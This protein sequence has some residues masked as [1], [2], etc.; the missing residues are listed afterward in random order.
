[1]WTRI[2]EQ[3][4]AN[5]WPRGR[6]EQHDSKSTRGHETVQCSLHDTRQT[7]RSRGECIRE[8][9]EK[10]PRDNASTCD[11][12]I[13]HP[14]VFAPDRYASPRQ[15]AQCCVPCSTIWCIATIRVFSGCTEDVPVSDLFGS[16]K[17][18]MYLKQ[19]TIQ[20]LLRPCGNV[21]ETQSQKHLRPEGRVPDPPT[22]T[23]ATNIT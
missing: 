7:R 23:P 19:K 13:K 12:N 8:T 17:S 18:N 4:Q 15:L 9:Q 22:H 16:M 21:L 6:V 1:M 20:T 11:H 5:L 3:K 2:E 14:R 10:R